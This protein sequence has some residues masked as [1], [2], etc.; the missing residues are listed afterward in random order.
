MTLIKKPKIK[1]I[2]KVIPKD[3]HVSGVKIQKGLRADDSEY[4]YVSI[5]ITHNEYLTNPEL[6][7]PIDL[8]YISMTAPKEERV[9]IT[10]NSKKEAR[11]RLQVD[12][13]HFA[14][15]LEPTQLKIKGDIK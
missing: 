14:F 7:E 5:L 13:G 3:Y 8:P 11:K 6:F 2:N 1:D 15:A 4:F 12:V 9:K 10:E